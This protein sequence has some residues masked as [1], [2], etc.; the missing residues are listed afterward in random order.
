MYVYI[1]T[2]YIC[3][4]IYIDIYIHMYKPG[5]KNLLCMH[6]EYIHIDMSHKLYESRINHMCHDNCCVCIA[7]IHIQ[8]RVI[9]KRHES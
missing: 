2:T 4:Y 5:H 8:K 9:N 3:I 7:S 6:R 1:Y